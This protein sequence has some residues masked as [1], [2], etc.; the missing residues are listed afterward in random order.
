[1]ECGFNDTDFPALQ[2]RHLPS[3]HVRILSLSNSNGARLHEA[4]RTGEFRGLKVTCTI[5]GGVDAPIRAR[6]EF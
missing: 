1:M 5:V 3:R 4:K 2:S 6:H